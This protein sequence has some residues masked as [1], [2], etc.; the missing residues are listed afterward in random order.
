MNTRTEK[1]DNTIYC[2]YCGKILKDEIYG[3]STYPE[4]PL[5]CNCKKAKIELELCDELKKLY[6]APL[7][8][9]LIDVKVGAYRNALVGGNST[10]IKINPV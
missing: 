4:Q 3:F 8:D 2:A 10:M 5:I 9:S 7:A 1:I 6:N